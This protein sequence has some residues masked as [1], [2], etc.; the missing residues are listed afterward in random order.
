MLSCS[1]P[2]G[3]EKFAFLVWRIGGVTTFRCAGYWY[4]RNSSLHQVLSFHWW[5]RRLLFFLVVLSGAGCMKLLK[6]WAELFRNARW[7]GR[8]ELFDS[9]RRGVHEYPTENNGKTVGWIVL[10][11]LIHFLKC[12]CVQSRG[13]CAK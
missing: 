7:S 5:P 9:T 1:H 11:H 10:S 13:L 2:S 4:V 6:R 8:K 12:F 3:I